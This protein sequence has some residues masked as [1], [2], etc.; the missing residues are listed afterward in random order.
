MEDEYYY[1]ISIII[2]LLV[3]A[4]VAV[5]YEL[6]KNSQPDIQQW[7]YMVVNYSEQD[8]D[9]DGVIG[10]LITVDQPEFMGLMLA[11]FRPDIEDY[12]TCREENAIGQAEL[13]ALIGAAGWEMI[14]YNN[15]SSGYRYSATYVFKRLVRG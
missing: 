1:I 10:T 15:T 3:T 2:A 8:M 13:L 6:G 4:M 14:R 12:E 11:C 5:V 7:Q 9:S